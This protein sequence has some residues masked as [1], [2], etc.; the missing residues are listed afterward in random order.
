MM[1]FLLLYLQS[2]SSCYDYKE[3]IPCIDNATWTLLLHIIQYYYLSEEI[4]INAKW[5]K[6]TNETFSQVKLSLTMNSNEE[7][8]INIVEVAVGEQDDDSSILS[9]GDMMVL[10]EYGCEMKLLK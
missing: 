4:K 7:T 6:W 1:A 5:S 2:N 10:D 3:G 8:C 9:P